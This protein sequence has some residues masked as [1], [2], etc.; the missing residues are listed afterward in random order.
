MWFINKSFAWSG[1]SSQHEISHFVPLGQKIRDCLSRSS[2]SAGSAPG[3]L[4]P[5]NHLVVQSLAAQDLTESSITNQLPCWLYTDSVLGFLKRIHCVSY[6]IGKSITYFICDQNCWITTNGK[7]IIMLQSNVKS[8][9][10]IL[11]SFCRSNL[12]DQSTGR[13]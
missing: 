2:T 11:L 10:T 4:T 13:A 9:V 1:I 5:L 3:L 8:I 6:V 7:V 12:Q